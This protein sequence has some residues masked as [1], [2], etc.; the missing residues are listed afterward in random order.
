M[1]IRAEES[2]KR[3]KAWAPVS[4]RG[5][6]K[7]QREAGHGLR[8]FEPDDIRTSIQQCMLRSKLTVSPMYYWPDNVLW[9][10][11]RDRK[12]PYCNL[13]D[14]GFPRLGCVGCPQAREAG[15]RRDFERWPGFYRLYLHAA[16]RLIDDGRFSD[17]G[18]A[19]AVM[20][21]WLSDKTQETQT[22][23]QMEL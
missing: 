9:S 14:E 1:G 19:E 16:Q 15:R 22:E 2:D 10:F 8:L 6:T 5:I 21:W 7:K 20:E 4:D 12:M 18:S 3:A 13:Y 11:I 17:K 23:G